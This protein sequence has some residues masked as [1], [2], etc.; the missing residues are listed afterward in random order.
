[1]SNKIMKIIKHLLY[2]VISNLLY[3]FVVYFVYTLLIG[4][5]LLYVYLVNLVLIFLFFVWD[6]AMVKLW[7][8]K[9]ISILLKKEKDTEKSSRQFLWFIDAF[10]SFKTVLYLF[11]II[12]L[13]IAQVIDSYPTLLNE[14]LA[15]FILANNY[16]I[17]VL[18]AA[19][20]LTGQFSK[21]RRRVKEISAKIKKE[22]A[23]SRD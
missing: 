18:I 4:Y 19:D 8:S 11:Y 14:N 5:S 9:K 1:M 23:E 20:Q 21:D 13:I 22:F 6:E 10:V 3:G 15:N 16:S 7:E 17:L 2:A 12:I